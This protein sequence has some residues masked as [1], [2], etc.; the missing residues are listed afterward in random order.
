[1]CSGET[2]NTEYSWAKHLNKTPFVS[3]Q[4]THLQFVLER[5][6]D[7]LNRQKFGVII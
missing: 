7:V 4:N 3:V 1:M 5:K 6:S 2:V